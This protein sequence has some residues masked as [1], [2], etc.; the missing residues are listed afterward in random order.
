MHGSPSK[1]KDRTFR[2]TFRLTAVEQTSTTKASKPVR[3]YRNPVTL[4][5]EWNGMIT[6]GECASLSALARRL[7]ISRA[8]VTQV[9]HL[10]K[11]TPQGPGRHY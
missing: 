3:L 4:A 2:A 9:L 10:L 11:L 5:H 6:N 7:G 1:L 8:R